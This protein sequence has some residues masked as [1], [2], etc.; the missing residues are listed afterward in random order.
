MIKDT[1]DVYSKRLV[2]FLSTLGFKPIKIKDIDK[3]QKHVWIYER[4]D[5]IEECIS[6][7]KWYWQ[8]ESNEWTK[9]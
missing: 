2:S 7:Y 6:F 9:K 4:T 8:V 1:I 5:R 3:Y